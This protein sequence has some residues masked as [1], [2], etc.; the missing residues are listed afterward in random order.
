MGKPDVFSEQRISVLAPG[1][2]RLSLFMHYD[3]AFASFGTIMDTANEENFAKDTKPSLAAMERHPVFTCTPEQ[4]TYNHHS[5]LAKWRGRYYFAWS[6]G[7]VNEDHPG[8]NVLISSSADGAE[9]SEPALVAKGDEDRGI[10]L[11]VIGLYAS[12]DMMVAYT[13]TEWN[14]AHAKNPGMSNHDVRETPW[15]VDAHYTTD[16]RTW[17]EKVL[18][19]RPVVFFEAPRPTAGGRLMTGASLDGC[20]AVC[21]WDGPDPLAEP[22]LVMLPY[23]GKPGEDYWHGPQAGI[24][25]YGE[26]SWYQTKDGRMWLFHRDESASGYLRIALSEDDGESWT[27]PMLSDMPDSMSRVYAG[28]LADGRYYLVG[29]SVRQLMDRGHLMLSISE[30]G[31]TFTRMYQLIA[32][33]ARQRFR[34]TLKVD[35]YQYPVGLVDGERLLIG[36]SVNKE[37]IECGIVDCAKL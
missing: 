20:P 24:F 37:D 10:V 15:R 18:V 36:Y 31:A 4:G 2:R 3:A 22:R 9:W 17:K 23:R 32:E 33:P 34:G 19:N 35:G 21:I 26:S 25:P 8:Q 13:R 29:N 5:Q 16:G 27:A 1:L 11:T 30:D 28:R 6:I 7:K 14:L 12:D